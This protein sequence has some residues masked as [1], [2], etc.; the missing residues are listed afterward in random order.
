MCVVMVGVVYTHTHDIFHHHH[1]F[2]YHHHSPPVMP[3]KDRELREV[4]MEIAGLQRELSASR[5]AMHALEATNKQLQ[6]QQH[7]DGL[8]S[9]YFQYLMDIG[10]PLHDPLAGWQQPIGPP[11][12]KGS[13]GDVVVGMQDDDGDATTSTGEGNSEVVDDEHK[14]DTDMQQGMCCLVR[15]HDVQ[16]SAEDGIVPPTHNP[17]HRPKHPPPTHPRLISHLHLQPWPLKLPLLHCNMQ[18]SPCSV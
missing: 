1:V 12:D 9:P 2:L 13:G 4:R 14:H 18:K 15:V 16:T 6:A 17:Q 10:G 3:M 7:A 5:A 11:K 8:R